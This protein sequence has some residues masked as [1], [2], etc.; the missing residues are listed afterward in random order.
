MFTPQ[1]HEIRQYVISEYNEL[2]K[3]ILVFSDCVNDAKNF[4]QVDC[5]DCGRTSQK[6]VP[7]DSTS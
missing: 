3:W 6:L 1:K 7:L 4:T 2:F 5:E